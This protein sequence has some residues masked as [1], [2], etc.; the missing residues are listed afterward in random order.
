MEQDFLLGEDGDLLIENGDF[1]VGDSL[2][3]EVQAILEMA[4]GELKEDPILGVD[5]FRLVHSNVTEADLKQRVKLH[6]ARDGK[7]YDELKERIRLK[8]N[9]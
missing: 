7:D 5:I 4:Q 8:T 2:D 9:E 1:V 3:Q 6:L